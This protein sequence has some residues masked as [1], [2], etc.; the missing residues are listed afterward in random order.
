MFTEEFIKK[1]V[2]LPK[3]TFSMK[4]NLHSLE[5]SIQK[6]WEESGTYNAILQKNRKNEKWVLH[7]GPPYANG[8]I[9]VGTGLNKI[10]K[11]IV[12][13][14]KSMRG[15]YSPY[16]PGWDCHGLP[17]ERKALMDS[18]PETRNDPLKLRE[19]CKLFALKYLDIQRE[20][21]KRLGVFG[22]WDQPYKTLDPEYEYKV[23]QTFAQLVEKGYVKR[24]LRP[25][26][27]CIYD[28]TALAEAE[29]EYKQKESD[30]IYV[31]FPLTRE[32]AAH[33]GD[34][35]D[36]DLIIWTTTPWTLPANIATAL[37]PEH[38]YIIINYIHEG[39][40]RTGIIMKTLHDKL[41]ELLNIQ[42]IIKEVPG[43]EIANL[44]YKHPLVDKICKTVL[45]DYVSKEEGTGLVHTAPGHGADDFM[46]AQKYQLDV[47]CPVNEKGF[48]TAEAGQ[49][50]GKKIFDAN[51][52]IVETLR[53]SG[54]LLWNGKLSH[55]YPHCWRCKKPVIFRATKQ[56]FIDINIDTNREKLLKAINESIKWYPRWGKS[57][58]ESMV[59]ER[60]NWCISRQRKWGIP[61]P[62]IICSK[63]DK[64]RTDGTIVNKVA[65][66]VRKEGTD[67]WYKTELSSIVDGVKC[68]N[69]GSKEFIK[70]NSTFDVWFDSACSH[71]GV[72]FDDD[73]IKAPFELYLEGTDQHRGWFQV[74]LIIGI[75]TEGYAPFKNCLT[76]GFLVEPETREKI[77]KSTSKPEFL[78]PAN[79]F[80]E[81]YGADVLRLWISSINYTNDIPFASSIL[82]EKCDLYRRIRNC[83]RFMLGNINDISRDELMPISQLTQLD[84]W[85]L[86]KL[87]Q[88]RDEV[89]KHYD[90][91]EFYKVFHKLYNFCDVTLSSTY[92]DIIK[93]ILYTYSKTSHERR[94]CQTTLH[95]ILDVLTKLFA[96]I[97]VHTTEEVWEHNNLAEN[98]QSIHLCEWPE[99]DLPTISNDERKEWD[100]LF[101]IR[102]EINKK[103]D[104][105]RKEGIVGNSLEAQCYIYISNC[106]LSQ[107]IEK[108]RNLLPLVFIASEVILTEKNEQFEQT[109]IEGLHIKLVKSPHKKCLRCWKRLESVSNNEDS[110][111]VCAR[112]YDILIKLSSS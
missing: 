74:S 97:L 57:R 76:H 51:S 63:C 87:A 40:T 39:S 106:E 75:L 35:K 109:E 54:L 23:L 55:S 1:S 83:F 81:K 92:F 6:K 30:S 78:L 8:D 69:C 38:N 60:P 90:E 93:D 27:W 103:I 101:K 104:H 34:F 14:Y 15:Y 98:K 62:A 31:R 112:C 111:D 66:I 21:F 32:S 44:E 45:A 105:A 80:A 91:Y 84:K 36:I 10:L 79:K 18:T 49:F 12:H 56:W 94:S 65:E 110:V 72:Q 7:D 24:E 71:R 43:S 47:I 29:L 107:V 16:K 77:S 9:H 33:L 99:I 26:H 108:Y 88:L 68:T 67:A 17:I 13:R 52:A 42:D 20:Q 102:N 89:T 53:S 82:E 100:M 41:K 11:D 4:A 5:P 48:F 96:P 86:D 85:I 61:I 50:E 64:E 3:T 70:E 25:I 37:H 59:K 19:K 28:A 73:S 22:L 2:N 95:I 58:I 46:T